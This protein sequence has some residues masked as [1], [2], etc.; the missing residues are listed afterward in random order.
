MMK[1][2]NEGLLQLILNNVNIL[3]I[4]I[5]EDFTIQYFNEVMVKD[6]GYSSKDILGREIKDFIYLEDRKNFYVFLDKTIESQSDCVELRILHHDGHVMETRVSSRL[7]NLQ[8]EGR[9]IILTFTDITTQKRYESKLKLDDERLTSLL[10]LSSLK[11]LPEEEFIDHAIEECVRLTESKIGYL[12]FLKEDE[13]TIQS[14]RWSK[15]IEEFCTSEST[16]HSSMDKA[17]V[18]ADSI[19]QRKPIIHNYYFKLP[20]KKAEVPLGHIPFRRHMSIPIFDGGKIVGIVGVGNKSELYDTSDV[21]QLSLFSENVWRI[22]KEKRTDAQLRA[23]L[24]KQKKYTDVILQNSQFKTEFLAT[25]SHELR[26]PLNIIIGFSDILIEKLYGDINDDQMDFLDN[27]SSSATHLLHLINHIIDISKIESGKIELYRKQFRLKE[28]VN[29]IQSTIMPLYEEKH[30]EFSVQGLSQEQDQLIYAD[31][32][33]LKE[34]LYNLLSNAIKYTIKG[35]VQLKIHEWEDYWQFDVIDTG[36]GIEKKDFPLLFKEFQRI[37]NEYVNATPGTGLGLSLTKR[38]VQ[39][40]GGKIWFE[41][42][43]GKGSSFMFT[44]PKNVNL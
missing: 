18:W 37:D 15:N 36:I 2:E 22:I 17:G 19:R 10:K 16:F 32:L 7:V 25:M 44:I 41:S 11:E 12:H 23:M 9:K 42:E 13:K 39:L 20:N 40:H 1:I 43:I 35:H 30:L 33:R 14:H 29:Q 8:E 28:I 31:R 27:I 34:I 4:F 38:L 26:T 24:E 21:H 6:L 3:I 5:D